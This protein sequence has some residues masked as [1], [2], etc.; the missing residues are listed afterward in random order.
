MGIF[1]TF[2][3]IYNSAKNLYNKVKEYKPAT[4]ILENPIY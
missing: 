1:D 2:K 3:N 4:K